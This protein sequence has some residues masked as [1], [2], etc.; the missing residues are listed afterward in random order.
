MAHLQIASIRDDQHWFTSPPDVPAQP[1]LFLCYIVRRRFERMLVRY[2]H[3]RSQKYNCDQ[4][5]IRVGLF[6]ILVRAS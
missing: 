4:P 5:D 1:F 6:V 3:Y 2:R